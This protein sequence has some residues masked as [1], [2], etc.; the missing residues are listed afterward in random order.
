MLEIIE[1]QQLQKQPDGSLVIESKP[2]LAAPGASKFLTHALFS[3]SDA[4][5]GKRSCKVTRSLHAL[6]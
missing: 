1:T 5:N 2:L 6:C 4:V 3:M